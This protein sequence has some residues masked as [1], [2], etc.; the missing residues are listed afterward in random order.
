MADKCKTT[1]RNVT[2]GQKLGNDMS[3][4][5]IRD[6]MKEI[7]LTSKE[8][9]VLFHGGKNIGKTYTAQKTLIDF[10]FHNDKEFVFMVPTE[11]EMKD[12]A[13][14]EYLKKCMLYEFSD[15][16]VRYTMDECF[17]RRNEGEDWKR[18]AICVPLSMVEK[19]YK[20]RNYPL[21][22][23]M[24]CDE[25]IVSD[26]K[27]MERLIDMILMLYD[28]VDRREDRVRC[29]MMGND[30]D[31][32]NPITDF[33]DLS[34]S[35][36]GPNKC[37]MVRRGNNK[38]SW[39][40]PTKLIEETG[41]TAFEKMNRGTKFGRYAQGIIETDYGHLIQEPP[42]D[43]VT[44]RSVGLQ[45]GDKDFGLLIKGNDGFLYI[46]SVSEPFMRQYAKRIYTTTFKRATAG[47]KYIPAEMIDYI[48]DAFKRGK[49]KFIDEESLIVLSSK[50]TLYLG[51]KVL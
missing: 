14:K 36:F 26:F 30:Q 49:L 20:K 45:F 2:D 17:V 11:K 50:I 32:K 9:F 28:T 13:L 10:C 27:L 4:S 29:I 31:K 38:L 21:V 47:E 51:F 5:E 22:D 16:D 35:D 24:I 42:E 48:K 40:V 34:I 8:K 41:E 46:E 12:Q 33:F 23:F 37:G 19:V 43:M 1:V 44:L 15:W 18:I 7:I 3:V 39:N 6:A 25:I